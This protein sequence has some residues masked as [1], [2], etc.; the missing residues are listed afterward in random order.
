MSAK[1]VPANVLHEL[2]EI[3]MTGQVPRADEPT[4]KKLG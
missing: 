1:V 3:L 4:V 2:G